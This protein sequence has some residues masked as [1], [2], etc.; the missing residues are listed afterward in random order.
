MPSEGEA[1]VVLGEGALSGPGTGEV[2]GSVDC[3]RRSS[4]ISAKRCMLLVIDHEKRT[5][6]HTRAR[7]IDE[8]PSRPV[9]EP[10]DGSR[11]GLH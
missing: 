4:L 5:D 1:D 7:A 8:Y 10:V 2:V 6:F 11:R 3:R 9:V